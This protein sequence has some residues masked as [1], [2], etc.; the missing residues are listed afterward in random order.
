MEAF[1]GYKTFIFNTLMPGVVFM[2]DAFGVDV[3]LAVDGLWAYMTSLE[4]FVLEFWAAG[5]V[6]LRFAT[7]TAIFKNR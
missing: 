3:S 2:Q 5:N 7:D 6:L 1:R 4:G